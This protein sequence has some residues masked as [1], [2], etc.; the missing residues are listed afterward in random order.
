M[1][2][3]LLDVAAFILAA[4]VVMVIH[5]LVKTIVFSV[6]Y[7]S[8][9]YKVQAWKLY[10]Y[11]DPIGLIFC[12]TTN[13]GFSKPYMLRIKEKRTNFLLGIVGFSTLLI[14][15][16]SSM[17]TFISLYQNNFI[18]K[19]DG[20]IFLNNNGF[21]SDLLYYICISSLGMFLVNLY[22]ISTFNMGLLIA[23]KSPSK[24][25]SI[26]KND[27]LIKMILII[28]LF[29]GVISTLIEMI[30]RLFITI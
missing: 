13:A 14:V 23:G 28:S 11:I 19:S 30:L 7:K 5:E 29:T 16:I 26:I 3:K 8:K 1:I 9:G 15:F 17:T 22:P 27:F 4:I 10:Q 12:I 24:Y 2:D 21:A 6:F 20:S 25:F 18:I